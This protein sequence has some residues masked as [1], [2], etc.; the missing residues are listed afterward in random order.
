[1]ATQT[2]TAEDLGLAQAIADTEDEIF[3]DANGTDPLDNDG[4]KSL[5]EMGDGLEGDHVEEEADEEADETEGEEEAEVQTQPPPTRGQ[6]IDEEPEQAEVP[7]APAEDRQRPG[8]VPSAVL[9]ERTAE[10]DREIAALRA[11]F[12]A[13]KAGAQRPVQQQEPPKPAEPP[14][15]FADPEGFRRHVI[16]QANA[17]AQYRH[18]EASLQDAAETHGEKFQAAYRELQNLGQ[19]ERNQFGNSPSITKIWNSPN[20]GR[21]LM[22]WHAQQQ[23]LKEVG[24]D[25]NA[26][27]EQKLQERLNDPDFLAQAVER[28]RG[29]A[30]QSG[31]REYTQP[32]NS[33]GRMP[34]SLNAASGSTQH[35]EDPDLYN[36]S[37]RAVFDFATR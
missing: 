12:E 30:R 5:E 7:A 17:A 4:D 33:R 23:T 8:M 26:W 22:S 3:R 6:G 15:M 31:A 35:V 28:A 37:E 10:K 21:A 34:P 2:V 14:D 19:S 24:N 25:P 13:F 36:P 27:L 1:M 29:S 16:E 32:A 18:V 20:P 9:R 11:E